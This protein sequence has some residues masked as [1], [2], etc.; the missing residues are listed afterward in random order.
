M[1]ALFLTTVLLTYSNCTH[2]HTRMGHVMP[3]HM[4]MSCEEHVTSTSV[5]LS[6]QHFLVVTIFKVLSSSCHLSLNLV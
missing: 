3:G 1:H 6:G 4:H 5:S 2:V